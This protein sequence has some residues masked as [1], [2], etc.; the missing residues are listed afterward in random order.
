[1]PRIRRLS[2]GGML[3]GVLLVLGA[4]ASVQFGASIAKTVFDRIDPAGLTL[5]RLA[6]AAVV[7]L[8]IARPRIRTWNRAAWRS[9]LFLG[10][11]L[12]GMNLL[13]YLALPRIP[14]AVAVT[15]EL[16]GPLL[17]ALVQSKRVV[18]FAWV[19][20]AAVG[21]GV[22]GVQSLGG[23]L[24]PIGVVLALAAGGCWA[25]YILASASVGKNVPG[26]GGL[27][28]ALVI[29]TVA[30]L[31]FGLMGAIGAVAA[32]PSVLLPAFAIAMLSSAIAYGLEMLALRRVATRVFGIMMA[33]EPAAAAIFGFLVVGE[34]LTGWDLLAL[35]LVVAASAG[36]ALTAARARPMPPETGQM[37]LI[38]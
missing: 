34:L 18:D 4:I 11:S 29:A 5:L 28:G 30:V 23:S 10:I 20:L 15:L 7:M 14:I 8:L 38:P 32:D 17:L 24:D 19:G 12:A 35:T 1:M 22:L 27:A 37:P 21:V 2:P 16:I 6:F 33:V 36:V 25:A 31:P 9:I 26:V 3:A 13:F